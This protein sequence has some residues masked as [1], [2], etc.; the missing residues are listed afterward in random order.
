MNESSWVAGFRVGQQGESDTPPPV[1]DGLAWMSGYIEGKS[2][3]LL[4]VDG[5]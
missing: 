2:K 4:R 5:P 3:S 1:S